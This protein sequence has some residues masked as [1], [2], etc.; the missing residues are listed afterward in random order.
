[1]LL[2]AASSHAFNLGPL[3]GA[4]QVGQPLDVSVPVTL[5]NEDQIANLC[6]DADVRYEDTRIGATLISIAPPSAGRAIVRIQSS[7]P[8]NAPVVTVILRI[9][10]AGP[11]ARR[12]V[13]LADAPAVPTVVA[14]PEAARQPPQ[15]SA[16]VAVNEAA[17]I[18][19][20]DSQAAAQ[21]GAPTESVPVSP[22]EIPAAQRA[23]R[24]ADALAAYEASQRAAHPAVGRAQAQSTATAEPARRAPRNARTAAGPISESAAQRRPHGAATHGAPAR[25]AAARAKRPAPREAEANAQ[26]QLS[27]QESSGRVTTGPR[28]E[29]DPVE[30]SAQTAPRLKAS[31]ELQHAPP[32]AGAGAGADRGQDATL[33]GAVPAPPATAASEAARLQALEADVT[34]LRAENQKSQARL[35]ELN[36]QLERAAERRDTL[37]VLLLALLAAAVLAALWLAWRLLRQPRPGRTVSSRRRPEQENALGPLGATII[38][39]LHETAAHREPAL[40][41]AAPGWAA[42][43]SDESER[44][45]IEQGPGANRAVPSAA[46]QPPHTVAEDAASRGVNAEELLDIQQQA[47]FFVSLGQ[48]EQAIELLRQHIDANAGTSPLAYLDLLSIYHRFELH[49]DYDRLRAEFTRIFNVQ[50]PS[51]EAFSAEGVGLDAYPSELARIETLWPTPAVVELIESFIFRRPDASAGSSELEPFAPEAYRELMLL[52]AIAKELAAEQAAD[53]RRAQR[54]GAAEITVA[55]DSVPAS[56]IPPAS[57]RLGIDIDLDGPLRRRADR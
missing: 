36:A 2:A 52:F 47:D 22:A 40:A 28:L 49:D 10:C 9:G 21:S 15:S 7:V 20:S 43:A 4:A 35:L 12:Y 53:A 50:V 30:S 27:Q 56:T 23:R 16:P 39:P 19:A 42:G 32:T 1:M 48:H 25:Q 3:R 5:A 18:A 38:S 54:T 31:P 33:S 44:A 41:G 17:A 14:S 8:V 24:M 45:S 13:L 6:A 55:T 51:F 11:V 26:A 29:L 46:P 37:L 34:A 57:P